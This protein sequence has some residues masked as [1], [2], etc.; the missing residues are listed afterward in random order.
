MWNIRDETITSAPIKLL[1]YTTIG[2]LPYWFLDPH[3]LNIHLNRAF[4]HRIFP[5]LLEIHTEA[6]GTSLN[7]I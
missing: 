1:S 7:P 4:T 3:Q 6:S 5:G 2:T